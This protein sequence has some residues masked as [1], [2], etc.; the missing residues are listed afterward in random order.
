MSPDRGKF[1]YVRATVT[2]EGD[3]RIE[4]KL[5]GDPNVTKTTYEDEFTL[6][7]R[8]QEVKHLVADLVGCGVGEVEL[9]WE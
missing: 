6:D 7:W 1:E 2:V 3:I 9:T 4:H 8:E 5:V